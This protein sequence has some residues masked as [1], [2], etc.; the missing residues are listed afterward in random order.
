MHNK[1][2]LIVGC[3]SLGTLLAQQNAHKKDWTYWGLRRQAHTLPSEVQPWSA[4]L[5][6]PQ[7]LTELPCQPTYVVYTATPSQRGAQGYRDAYVSGVQNILHALKPVQSSIRRILFVSSTSVYGQSD[8]S[9]IDEQSPATPQRETGQILLEGEECIRT[10]PVPS[11]ILRFGGIYG[12]RRSARLLKKV[13][14]KQ[15]L[16]KKELHYTNRIHEE[17]CVRILQYLLEHPAPPQTLLGVDNNPVDY[18]QVI[19]WMATQL[20]VDPP[21]D[22][23]HPEQHV[24][25]AGSKRCSNALLRSLG[26]DFLYPSYQEGYT[27]IIR[28]FRLSLETS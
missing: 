15:A 18:N 17:D 4:D 21:Q 8:G 24:H 28:N 22:T 9:W 25:R 26:Y 16:R 5:L 7:T 27:P 12:P 10:Y 23:S 20:Q 6:Q 1:N 13:H 11:T 19:Q 3:G 2:V 14:E